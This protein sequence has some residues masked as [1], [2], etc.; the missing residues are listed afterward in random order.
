[1]A[2]APVAVKPAAGPLPQRVAAFVRA[3]NERIDA[4]FERRWKDPIVA[5]VPSDLESTWRVLDAIARGK[6]APGR[7]FCEW[8]CGFAA[9][10]GLAALAGFQA[11]GIEIER[12]LLE[13]ARLLARDF[14]LDVELAQGNFVP[15]GAGELA[16]CNQEFAWLAEGGPDGHEALGLDPDDFDLVF[17]FPWPGEE[18]VIH[19]LFEAYAAPEALLV[20]FHGLEGLRVQRKTASGRRRTR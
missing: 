20:T 6:L 5:F 3:A 8:G 17:A 7:R 11:C 9:V 2:L 16:D 19:R 10:A 12:D 13:Q 18:D 15:A 4:F 14:S 1:M